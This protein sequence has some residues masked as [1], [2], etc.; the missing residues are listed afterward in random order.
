MKRLS[1]F[2]LL[3]ISASPLTAQQVGLEQ[4]SGL[5]VVPAGDKFLRWHGHV[6]RSYFVQ[7]SDTNNPLAKWTWAP[8]IEAGNDEEISYEIDGTSSKGFFRLKYT[9][10]PIPE[11]YTLDTADFDGDSLSNVDEINPPPPLLASAATDPL[12]PDTDGDGLNDGWEVQHGLNP[13][14][15]SEP[16]L[17]ADNDGL[18]NLEE[19]QH[20]TDPNN[21]DSDGDGLTDGEEVADG[22]DPTEPTVIGPVNFGFDEEITDSPDMSFRDANP[23]DL[24][25]QSS[26]PGWQ[27]ASGQHIEVW[28]EGDGNPY[29]E[30]QSHLDAHGVKQEFSMRPSS[31]LN[32]ILRY[33]GRYEGWEA[34][35][36]AF[37]LKVE[38]A[39]EV[40][41]DGNAAGV[42]GD[43]RSKSFMESDS[44]TQWETWHHAYVSITAPPSASG[45]KQ[46]KLSLVPIT[47]TS[48]S[49]EITRGGFVD[50][51]PVEISWKAFD[52]FDNVDD[53]IDP[54]T[55]SANGKR[56][57][58]DFKNPDESEIQHKLEII[59]KT[60]PALA[61]KTVF[62]KAFDVDDST[63]E[64]F[65]VEEGTTTS[66]IDLNYEAGDDNLIDY[67]DVPK[68]G[69][70]WTGTAWG[71]ETAQG[72]V[73]ADGETKFQ[74]RV[75]MQPGNNYRVVAS[76]FDESMYSEVQTAEP[77]QVKYL[78]Y[79]FSENGG[80]PASPLLTV[81]R[82]LWV[83]NDSMKAIP[84]DAFGYKRNDLSWN[85]NPASINNITLEAGGGST[86][87][88]IPAITDQSS[89]LELENGHMILQSFPHPVT[90]THSFSVT[91]AGDHTAVPPGSGFRLYDDD[92]FGLPTAPLPRHNLVGD[93]LRNSFKPAF[94]QVVNAGDRNLRK[95][96]DFLIQKSVNGGVLGIGDEFWDEHKDLQDKKEC[97]V[98]RVI[99]AYQGGYSDDGDP[100]SESKS[101][102]ITPGFKRQFSVVYV[103]AVRDEYESLIRVSFPDATTLVELG[104]VFNAAHEIGHMPGTGSDSS[105]HDEEGIMA[106]QISVNVNALPKF[107]PA[108]ILRFRNTSKWQKP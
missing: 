95:T 48:S 101:Q 67:L 76:F 47:T 31:R 60:S 62:V 88:G 86:S 99:A 108:S 106:E 51:L 49:E 100:N 55:N 92:D 29:V 85:L 38:G 53:H 56:I 75:G 102:G 28:D 58:P 40:L 59:V 43:V 84:T 16:T 45:L 68:S 80:A 36:N 77:E 72:V 107:N 5:L 54:W 6:G 41:V 26:I 24:Y 79:Q 73:D 93:T 46:I 89:F 34:C 4:S 42:T 74:F 25:D 97:W 83:E 23:A 14:Q 98:A 105:H 35:D 50:F 96:L 44:G 21:T 11:G 27:A 78:G 12:N 71:G 69:Q 65:D 13:T 66:V 103:E 70:F 82:K 52:G 17:D 1:A 33:K 87:F 104:I 64:A 20:G 30:L 9:T 91:V 61:G 81:W 8:V 2:L 15:P 39:S 19:Y 90:D 57:F 18:T 7:V 37:T 3:L 94:I 10:M 32:F 22:T 63:S